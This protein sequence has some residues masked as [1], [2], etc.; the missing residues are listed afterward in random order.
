MGSPCPRQEL[1]YDET[2][3][4]FPFL[5]ENTMEESLKRSAVKETFVL[6]STKRVPFTVPLGV[7]RNMQCS[8][9]IG[10]VA[11][12]GEPSLLMDIVDVLRFS[13]ITPSL[14]RV[15]MILVFRRIL[16]PEDGRSRW[17]I[18]QR[19]RVIKLMMTSDGKN[20]FTIPRT[21]KH[22]RIRNGESIGHVHCTE[23]D[24]AKAR[25]FLKSHEIE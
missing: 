15:G 25:N 11:R 3:F 2:L 12:Q 7:S 21:T 8:F 10:K 4:V 16:G 5:L 23:D 9:S 20:G 24:V 6:K 14:V 19:T 1:R 18:N 22:S 13:K 17:L